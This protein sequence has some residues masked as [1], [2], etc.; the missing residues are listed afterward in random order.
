MAQ[1]P[2]SG[3][4][5]NTLRRLRKEQRRNRAKK[6]KQRRLPHSGRM[7][8]RIG[9]GMPCPGTIAS[10]GENLTSTRHALGSG[11]DLAE[12]R[13]PA[14]KILPVG[15]SSLWVLPQ[16]PGGRAR[17]VIL[18]H[19][20]AGFM[21]AIFPFAGGPGRSKLLS[22]P[23]GG[24]AIPRTGQPVRRRFPTGRPSTENQINGN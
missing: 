21:A 24:P 1:A 20:A 16:I 3:S 12:S 2:A 4:E 17:P 8:S 7:P 19:F 5:E 10:G 15:G 23:E 14:D 9:S 6:S 22:I 11:G 13:S 18:A